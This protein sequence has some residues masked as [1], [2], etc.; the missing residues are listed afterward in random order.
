MLH[1]LLF[2]KPLLWVVCTSVILTSCGIWERK[3]NPLAKDGQTE[4]PAPLDVAKSVPI[5]VQASTMMSITTV[6]GITNQTPS[7][8]EN[9]YTTAF[10]LGEEFILKDTDE[11]NHQYV[12]WKLGSVDAGVQTIATVT[13]RK[14]S[15][16]ANM[17]LL[18]LEYYSDEGSSRYECV[19]NQHDGKSAGRAT[20]VDKNVSVK[21]TEDSF[22][23]SCT[24]HGLKTQSKLSVYLAP[25][26]GPSLTN[27]DPSV[28]GGVT[29]Q[30]MS[31]VVSP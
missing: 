16:P 3:E 7:F 29:I 8:V 5:E 6:S 18:T 11:S 1:E 31:I 24:G 27:Y 30:T 17:S 9:Y 19:F 22:Q 25:A 26:V 15:E 4:D 14:S 28:V 21:D 10:K 12:G 13:V 23:I 2:K 20:A